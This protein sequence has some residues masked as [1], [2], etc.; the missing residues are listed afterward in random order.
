MICSSIV[1]TR[2]P[3]VASSLTIT[4]LKPDFFAA[5]PVVCPIQNTGVSLEGLL[6]LRKAWTA[7]G[8]IKTN[9]S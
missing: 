4:L 7:D 8:L 9:P 5:I 1:L 6:E 3:K 2:R